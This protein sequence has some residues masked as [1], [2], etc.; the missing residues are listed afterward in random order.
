MM[1][2]KYI[3]QMKI[4]SRPDIDYYYTG[5][6]DPMGPSPVFDYRK[7]KAKR[8][9]YWEEADR[10]MRILAAVAHNEILTVTTVKCRT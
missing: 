3:I 7:P 4:P 1:Q 2:T 5:E 10:D 8:Y 9:T 6:Y